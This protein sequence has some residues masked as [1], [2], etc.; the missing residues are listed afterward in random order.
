[1]LRLAECESGF[2]PEALNDHE[3]IGG[4]SYGLYQWQVGSWKQYNETFKT[5][6]DRKS[7]HDQVKMSVQVVEKYGGR[8]WFNCDF[9]IRNGYWYKKPS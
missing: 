5:A 2:D 7:W 8:D 4:D 6:Y 9:F 3:P 1:M